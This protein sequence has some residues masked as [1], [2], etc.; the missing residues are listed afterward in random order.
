MQL[1]SFA[2]VPLLSLA[3]GPVFSIILLHDWFNWISALSPALSIHASQ[4]L[5]RRKQNKHSRVPVFSSALSLTRPRNLFVLPLAYNN[6]RQSHSRTQIKQP[7]LVFFSDRQSSLL[8]L[9]CVWLAL[10][11][12]LVPSL[13]PSLTDPRTI[14]LPLYV[15]LPIFWWASSACAVH[16][17]IRPQHA[18]QPILCRCTAPHRRHC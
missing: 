2:D 3:G 18:V 8:F 17:H 4:W 16:A 10:C 12:H 11:V 5:V 6:H 1:C 9:P 15:H 13:R 7:T 14:L